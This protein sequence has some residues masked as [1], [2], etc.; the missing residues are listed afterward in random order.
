MFGV[1]GVVDFLIVFWFGCCVGV[2]GCLG[3]GFEFD[4]AVD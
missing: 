4:T 3:M 1:F 2:G